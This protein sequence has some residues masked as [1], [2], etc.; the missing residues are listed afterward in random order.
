MATKYYTI[1]F[2]DN[3]TPATG[4]SP[5]LDVFVDLATS[6]PVTPPS[7]TE[8]SGGMYKF[9]L[10]WSTVSAGVDQI[11]LR[12]DSEDVGMSDADRYIYGLIER[13]DIFDVQEIVTDNNVL[14]TTIDT[15]I[16]TLVRGNWVIENNQLKLY[17]EADPITPVKTF[18]LFDINGDPTSTSA[19]SRIGV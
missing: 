17:T 4:L 3:G 10:D 15:N 8:I 7:I 11:A 5:T 9:A 13:Q 19:T 6:T 12:V 14:L 2:R 16:D 1:T 18:D